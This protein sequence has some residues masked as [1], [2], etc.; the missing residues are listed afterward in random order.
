MTAASTPRRVPSSA[1]T[2]QSPPERITRISSGAIRHRSVSEILGETP[3]LPHP[4]TEKLLADGALSITARE[5]FESSAAQARI[6]AR[7]EQDKGKEQV[8]DCGIC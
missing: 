3:K 6:A 5:D 1:S 8:I 2:V 7:K 4:Q